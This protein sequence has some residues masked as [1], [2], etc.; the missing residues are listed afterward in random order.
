MIESRGGSKF[1]SFNSEF[2]SQLSQQPTYRQAY[3]VTETKF[4]E[5]VGHRY[6]KDYNSFKSWR[7]QKRK[8]G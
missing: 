7:S 8:R 6:Y 1:D 4:S 3:E 2:E 5:L